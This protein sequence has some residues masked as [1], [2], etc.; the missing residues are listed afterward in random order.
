MLGTLVN[1]GA[2]AIGSLLG[3]CIN[4]RLPKRITGIAF[5]AIGL[6]T[7]ILGV[8]MALETRNFIIMILSIVSGS[9]I[10]EGLDLDMQVTKLGNWLKRRL[11]ASHENFS[12]GF[13]TAF[14]LYCMGS[15]T[16]L[17]AIEEGLGDEPNLL[18]AKSI[19]DGVSSIALAATLGIG[20]LFSVLPLLAYQGGLTLFAGSLQQVL[21]NM[22]IDEISAVG[23]ILLLGLGITLLEIKQI[24]VLNMLPSLLIAG[25]L[26]ALF[27]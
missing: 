19:L 6:F 20:V 27:L 8:T 21:T 9:I 18:L 24:K 4:T 1:A 14:L 5:Q 2:V 16:I 7:L 3:L 11:G 12:E 25:I 22:V 26:A 23:G 13:V 17:G 10:G 15:M